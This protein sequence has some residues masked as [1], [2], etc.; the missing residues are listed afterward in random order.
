MAENRTIPTAKSVP[1]FLGQISDSKRKA[2]CITIFSLFLILLVWRTPVLSQETVQHD[3]VHP[4]FSERV[5]ERERMVKKGIAGYPYHPVKDPLVL[6]AM[7]RVPRHLFVPKEYRKLAY[8]NSPLLIGHNQTISQPFIVAHMSELLELEPEHRVLEVGTGS[9]YQAAVLGELCNHVYTIEIVV[10]LGR[11]AEKLLK[12][13]GYNQ[14]QVRI[15]DGYEGWPEAA[16]FDRIIVT[17]APEKIPQP[18]LEQLAPDGRM[19]IPVGRQFG[20]QYMV[21]VTKDRKGRISQKQHYPVRF[22]PMTGKSEE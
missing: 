16:P 2:D 21:E 12:E 11:K 7:R 9:G 17:C 19:V 20:T 22:V 8:R 18:L 15:G 13:L 4:G 6:Q 14:V 10:P 1:E 3:R 5:E